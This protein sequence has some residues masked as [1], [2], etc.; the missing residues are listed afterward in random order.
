MQPTIQLRTCFERMAVEE[1][2]YILEWGWGIL[3]GTTSSGGVNLASTV[4]TLADNYFL[5]FPVAS[6]GRAPTLHHIPWH[7]PYN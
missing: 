6:A 1:I 5:G 3:V 4:L 2:R 7:L